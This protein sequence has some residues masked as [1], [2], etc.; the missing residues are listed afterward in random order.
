MEA[1]VL[2]GSDLEIAAKGREGSKSA[3]KEK[4]GC[5]I[6]QRLSQPSE[7]SVWDEKD[8]S[9]YSHVNQSFSMGCLRKGHDRTAEGQLPAAFPLQ[10]AGVLSPSFSKGVLPVHSSIYPRKSLTRLAEVKG[11]IFLG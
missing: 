10:T 3:Q 2:L 8:E 5:D 7:L 11:G 9:L 4:L 1:A 6:G